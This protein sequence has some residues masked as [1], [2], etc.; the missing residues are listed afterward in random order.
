[1]AYRISF[2]IALIAALSVSDQQRNNAVRSRQ[3]YNIVRRLRC[4]WMTLCR[5]IWNVKM[6]VACGFLPDDQVGLD[7]SS[8][9]DL[10]LAH[11]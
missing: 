1:M 4:A 5:N 6:D 11:T 8:V 9:D 10:E 3:A 7:I 2:K